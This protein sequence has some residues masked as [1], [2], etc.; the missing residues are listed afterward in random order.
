MSNHVTKP[1]KHTKPS[2]GVGG[3]ATASP[4]ESRRLAG[5]PQPRKKVLSGFAS[6]VI[7]KHN[8]YE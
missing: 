2:F 5:F 7:K 3:C 6:F 1:T 4:P 8:C